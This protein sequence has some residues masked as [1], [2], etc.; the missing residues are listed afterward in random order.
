MIVKRLGAWLAIVLSF[1]LSGSAAQLRAAEPLTVMSYNIRY[2]NPQ[3]GPDIWT[4]RR[5]TVGKMLQSA[6]V[7]GLQEVLA[8]QL[9][10]LRQRLPEFDWYGVGRDDGQAK[11]E[12]VPIG[13]RK[14]RI[15]CL[16]QGTFWLS[17]EPTKAGSVGWDAALPRIAS[18]IR[19][20]DR[21]SGTEWLLV[22]THFD[23]RGPKA[24]AESGKLLRSWIAEHAGSLPCILTG[25]FNAEI[26]SEPMQNLLDPQRASSAPA[27]ILARAVTASADPGP[28]STWNGFKKI[29]PGRRIDHILITNQIKVEQFKTL[30]P[31][32]ASGRFASDHLPI[33]ATLLPP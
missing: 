31:R 20:R 19:L 25:D 17:S 15:E 2:A 21:K 26:K 8:V 24:R 12:M 28:D 4:E 33:T 3:D 29:E 5:D 1:G 7:I 16:D 13:Y 18:W 27:L 9:D 30:D 14:E 6:D 22:N 23:H 11:G 10:D 32:T